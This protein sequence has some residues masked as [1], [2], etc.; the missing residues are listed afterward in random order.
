MACGSSRCERNRQSDDLPEQ[1]LRTQLALLRAKPFNRPGTLLLY[2]DRISHVPSMAMFVG[3]MSGPVSWVVA[4]RTTKKAAAKETDGGTRGTTVRLA[5]VAEVRKAGPVWDW[6]QL[7]VVTAQGDAMLVGVKYD[8]W[9]PDLVAALQ[10]AGR[11]VVDG[12]DVVTVT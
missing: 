5:D 3:V 9:K 2:R 12:G 6:G 11:T 8:Q 1:P 7:E 4:R 10:G